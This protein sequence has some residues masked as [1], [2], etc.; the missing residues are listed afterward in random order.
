M[1]L[2]L[3]IVQRLQFSR[4]VPKHCK[5]AANLVALFFGPFFLAALVTADIIFNYSG[6]NSGATGRL[7]E[8]LQNTFTHL[9]SMDFSTSGDSEIT[10]LSSAG[11]D[12]KEV[13]GHGRNKKEDRHILN[14]TE[15]IV[16]DALSE[17]ASDILIDPKD[18]S[19]YTIRLRVDGMLRLINEPEAVK[20]QAVINSI[21]AVSGMDIAE[22]RRPQDGAFS[23]QVAERIYSFRVASA[24]VVNG[25]KLSIRVL[26]YNAG[27]FKLEDIGLTNKQAVIIKEYIA[28][29]SGM[30]LMCGPTGS[31]KTSTL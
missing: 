14:L 2:C 27:T 22:K 24:G 28:K 6:I 31:G 15:E 3:Y 12:L 20:C 13:F 19:N 11:K 16:F 8:K 30:I 4:L 18:D 17:R 9:R 26:N 5:T 25:E 21:K 7:K 10:L 23:A 1:Y 29:P